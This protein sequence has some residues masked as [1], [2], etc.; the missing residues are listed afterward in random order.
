MRVQWWTF[1]RSWSNWSALRC[2]SVPRDIL[3]S[4]SLCFDTFF[5]TVHVQERLQDWTSAVNLLLDSCSKLARQELSRVRLLPTCLCTLCAHHHLVP[6]C[7]TI[8]S[9]HRNSG[10][11]TFMLSKVC[12]ALLLTI[13]TEALLRHIAYWQL[14]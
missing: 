4:L 9:H 2:A 1:P 11:C 7:I 12:C 6:D 14:P 3:S 10:L 8:S 5:G 13:D